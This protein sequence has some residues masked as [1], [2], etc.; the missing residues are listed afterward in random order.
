M[1]SEAPSLAELLIYTPRHATCCNEAVNR[2]TASQPQ[3]T[4]LHY[5]QPNR[6]IIKISLS[7]ANISAAQF[8]VVS[9]CGETANIAYEKLSMQCC[10]MDLASGHRFIYLWP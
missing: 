10:A 2:F 3:A 4:I 7:V 1:W 6:V 5:N 9:R 8:S